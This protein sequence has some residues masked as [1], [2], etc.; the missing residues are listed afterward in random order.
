MTSDPTYPG[1]AT[2]TLNGPP[3]ALAIQVEATALERG[4]TL[5]RYIV[6]HPLGQGGMGQV[7]AAY[8]P[9]LDRR[10]AIKVLKLAAEAPS[11]LAAR[12]RSEGRALARLGHPNVLTVF[13]VGMADQRFFI[14]T[15][16]VEGQTVDRW[17]RETRHWKDVLAVFLD[18]GNGI[19]AAHDEGL[20]HRDIKPGNMMVAADGRALVL[21]FGIARDAMTSEGETVALDSLDEPAVGAESPGLTRPGAVVGTPAFMAPEQ[22]LGGSV[23]PQAD[24]YS[25][26]LTLHFALYGSFP[27]PSP[28]SEKVRRRPLIPPEGTPAAGNIPK[29]L[30]R[31][32]LSGLFHDPADRPHSMGELIDRLQSF[33]V[34]DRRLAQRSAIAGLIALSV[35][36]AWWGRQ[37]HVTPCAT[38]GQESAAIWSAE[39]RSGLADVFRESKSPFAADV[40]KTVAG[41]L[42]AYAR[43]WSQTAEDWCRAAADGS[44]STELYDL[45]GECME[46]R[47]DEL[48]ATVGLL[49]ADPGA[50]VSRAVDM[51]DGLSPVA[52]CADTRALRAPSPVPTDE[53]A[54]S[55]L[56]ALRQQQAETRA[57]WLAGDLERSGRQ[58]VENLRQANRLG[59]W[60]AIAE[61]HLQVAKVKDSKHDEGTADSLVEAALAAAAGSH[62]QLA[63]EAFVRLVRVVGLHLQD[64]DRA[65]SHARQAE[66]ALQGLGRPGDLTARLWDHQGIVARQRGDYDGALDHL[67]RSLDWKVEA[68]GDDHHQVAQTLLR[69]GGVYDDLDDHGAAERL[70]NRALRIQLVR[71]GPRHPTVAEIYSRLGTLARES[72]DLNRALENHEKAMAIHREVFGEQSGRFAQSLTYLGELQALRGEQKAAEAS[73][74]RA[75]SLMVE[76]Y[77]A[78]SYSL[79]VF[80]AT[81]GSAWTEAGRDR[82]AVAPLRR[83]LEILSTKLGDD[84]DR[85]GVL[86]FNLATV[87]LRLGEFP[88]AVEDFAAAAEIWRHSVGPRHPRIAA[89]VTGQ[90]DALVRLGRGAEALELLRLAASIDSDL[91]AD[92]ARD[93]KER[94][95]TAFALARAL[96]LLGEPSSTFLPL[97][98][99]AQTLYES[100]PEASARELAELRPWLRDASGEG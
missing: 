54:R 22:W 71:L 11:T 98:G 57:L 30:R 97:A 79:V 67:K 19:A 40:W 41:G 63:A 3:G 39:R 95:D 89:A 46:R 87:H 37:R 31:L 78:D 9:D 69:L 80:Y 86:R 73:F 25:Y 13:D 76:T 72:N 28:E 83:A 84:H 44:L 59:Y 88:Q 33:R 82:E 52:E 1:H 92:D 15:E 96:R 85:V 77:E 45:R 8:D 60:P 65:A 47:L 56:R 27:E 74:A 93:P 16:L 38:L 68:Y 62:Q 61:A 99:E 4:A 5:G 20:V 12:L 26:C 35:G 42:D 49:E 36:V 24:I 48:N 58:A 70:V 43:E 100:V 64:F 32:V 81:M 17:L 23:S 10:V 90:G 21:D 66:S 75:E 7:Y 91:S 53:P 34:R 2:E 6:L 51:V 29:G 50:R 14:A 18:I 94:A 55:R